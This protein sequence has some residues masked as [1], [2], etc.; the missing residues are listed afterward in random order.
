MTPSEVAG[1]H[2]LA[3]SMYGKPLTVNP[4]TGLVEANMLKRYIGAIVG[5]LAGA[6]GFSP[7]ISTVLGGLAGGA[8]N[9]F[10][11]KNVALQSLGARSAYEMGSNLNTLGAKVPTTPP[12]ATATTGSNTGYENI[13]G[14]GPGPLAANN[15][16]APPP[17]ATTPPPAAPVT[18]EPAKGFA[19][20]KQSSEG[21]KTLLRDEDA[22]E[23]F[24]NSNIFP[25][26]GA[27]FSGALTPEK[28][29]ASK[30]APAE[31]YDA[32]FDVGV[33]N[34]DWQRV[35][36]APYY[37]PRTRGI[38]NGRYAPASDPYPASQNYWWMK[39]PGAAGGGY[40][41]S[42]GDVH[43]E[44]PVKEA[45]VVAATGTPVPTAPDPRLTYTSPYSG[46]TYK[47]PYADDLAA[48]I[49]KVNASLQPAP[50]T[51]TGTGTGGGGGPGGSGGGPGGSNIADS[52]EP[53]GGEN[54]GYPVDATGPGMALPP[55]RSPGDRAEYNSGG[56][57]FSVGPGGMGFISSPTRSPYVDAP[58]AKVPVQSVI[59]P[60]TGKRTDDPEPA[61]EDKKKEPGV[62]DYL[63]GAAS[64]RGDLTSLL[65]NRAIDFG[66]DT[67]RGDD[68]YVTDENGVRT[69]APKTATQN[70]VENVV[71]AFARPVNSLLHPIN[72]LTG[73]WNGTPVKPPNNPILKGVV[74]AYNNLTKT[75]EEIAREEKTRAK[76]EAAADKA[77]AS[78]NGQRGSG[79]TTR[80]SFD[81]TSPFF[82]GG[83]LRPGRVLV[84]DAA[85][86]G[87]LGYGY[88]YAGGGGIGSLGSYSDGGRFLKG[89]GDGVSDDIPGVIHHP[90]GGQQPARLATGEFVFP[91]R[92]VSEI[93]NGSSEA[94]AQKLYA[95]MDRIQNDRK[96]SIKDVA[97]DSN[98][99]RHFNSLMA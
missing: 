16:P 26:A 5:G 42:G 81:V 55:N 70:R 52:R 27:Y 82:Q 14:M 11:V 7:T 71:D 28:I 8:A 21:I 39:V 91:A 45:P 83:G 1:L 46:N 10:N 53:M 44:Q 79:L 25:I 89:P 23:K 78:G 99:E 95:I 67:L 94:G 17:P 41:A 51:G 58:P 98:A 85:H 64:L 33:I 4:K 18:V 80:N 49:G 9:G 88:G 65:A 12:P 24:F 19:G 47:S 35:P 76:K 2:S 43:T 61:K 20:L 34:P 38:T 3:L 32:N 22:Y 37:K 36:G 93:G 63:G 84:Q 57:G 96:R 54:T 87:M 13:E 56:A 62:F 75:P 66:F 59:D 40:F 92:I 69:D 74:G 72:T 29:A 60:E 68:S 77:E 15:T 86:G 50:R 31:R 73:I 30:F 90:D 48:Y 6:A 97:L